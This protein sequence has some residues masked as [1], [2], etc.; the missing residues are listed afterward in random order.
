MQS[1]VD[2]QRLDTLNIPNLGSREGSEIFSPAKS[3]VD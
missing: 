2:T 1:I 3:Y